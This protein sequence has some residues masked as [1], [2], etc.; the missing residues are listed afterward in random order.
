MIINNNTQFSTKLIKRIMRAA[1]IKSEP[2]SVLII[3]HNANKD[4]KHGYVELSDDYYFINIVVPGDI[5]TLAHELRHVAQWQ[6]FN[7]DEFINMPDEI[8]EIDAEL[9]EDHIESCGIL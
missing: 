8:L 5:L 7:R 3:S 2:N 1:D 6:R 9:F 4:G